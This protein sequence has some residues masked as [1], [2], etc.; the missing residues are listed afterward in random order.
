MGVRAGYCLIESDRK[1]RDLA[2][3][4]TAWTMQVRLQGSWIT[5]ERAD[6]AIMVRKDPSRFLVVGCHGFFSGET[7]VSCMKQTTLSI[8]FITRLRNSTGWARRRGLR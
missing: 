3:L 1:T 8:L 7:G 6:L 2:L 5:P 4:A